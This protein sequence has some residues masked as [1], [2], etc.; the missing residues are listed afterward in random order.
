MN[1]RVV[2]ARSLSAILASLVASLVWLLVG[3]GCGTQDAQDRTPQSDEALSTDSLTGAVADALSIEDSLE[4]AAALA[5]ALRALDR[6]GLGEV[7]RVW[8]LAAEGARGSQTIELALLV[9][10]WARYDPVGAFT[11][12][13]ERRR[14]GN[15][16]LLATLVRS[17]ASRAPIAAT[18][19]VD[20]LPQ[21]R[22]PALPQIV[23]AL[24]QGWNASGEPGVEEYL[25]ELPS[26]VN[27]QAGLTGLAVDKAWRSGIQDTIR[28][29]EALPDDAPGDFKQLAFRR[30]AG[31]ITDIDPIRASAWAEK[32]RGGE[33][34]TGL[35]RSVV[36]KW[37]LQ[38]GEPA[39]KWLRGLPDAG[40]ADVAR[41][42][43]EGYRSWLSTNPEVAR[44]WL[45]EQEL[46]ASLDPV[47]ALYAKSMAR[48]D[49]EAALPW[50]ARIRDESR[51]EEALEKIARAWLH[52]DPDAA[53]VWLEAGELPEAVVERVYAAHERVSA[54]EAKARARQGAGVSN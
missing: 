40:S 25:I 4:R 31:A 16:V 8:L 37:A 39:M 22:D 44:A 53:R 34:G 2:R 18:R 26:D 5:T 46:D 27:R 17:W 29:A 21:S 42:F 43:E 30:V 6:E 38:D 19:A 47:V 52:R 50:A 11:W 3:S 36:Q 45:L 35:V 10:W 32:Q 41:A 9:D 49:P 51:R 33:W 1:R 20:A 12:L 23:H 13:H 7:E 24:V 15:P 48:N 14:A 28:W 54:R